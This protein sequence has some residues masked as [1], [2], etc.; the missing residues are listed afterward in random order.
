MCSVQCILDFQ[1]TGKTIFHDCV[2]V[3]SLV[4]SFSNLTEI[5][6]FQFVNDTNNWQTYTYCQPFNSYLVN[7]WTSNKR[8]PPFSSLIL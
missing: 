6:Y 8:R 2:N 7:K 1:A 5:S 4:Q 3:D